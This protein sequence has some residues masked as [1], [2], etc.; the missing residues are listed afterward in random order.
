MLETESKWTVKI[1]ELTAILFH[2]AIPYINVSHIGGIM[3]AGVNSSIPEVELRSGCVVTCASVASE[4][5]LGNCRV[6]VS[7]AWAS[8]L[9]FE[10]LF[11]D[12]DLDFT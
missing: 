5:T 3:R 7:V 11:L 1:D 6:K 12:F 10:V 9:N 2:F 4:I 8:I